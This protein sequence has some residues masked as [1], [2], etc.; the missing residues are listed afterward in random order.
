MTTPIEEFMKP[1]VETPSEFMSGKVSA[2]PG[3]SERR[4]ADCD[5]KHKHHR[6]RCVVGRSI[7]PSAKPCR[8]KSF[9]FGETYRN[10]RDELVDRPW[11][12]KS[13]DKLVAT[14]YSK[15]DADEIARNVVVHSTVVSVVQCKGRG[16]FC[17]AL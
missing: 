17:G 6:P 12:V 16:C 11:H 5:H 4:C 7:D 9:A 15:R 3:L 1:P 2:K 10:A 14:R 13:H 8:C